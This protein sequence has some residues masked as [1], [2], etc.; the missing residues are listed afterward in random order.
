M[1]TAL[2][3]NLKIHPSTLDPQ[4]STLNTNPH[5]SIMSAKNLAFRGDSPETLGGAGRR[6]CK[7]EMTRTDGSAGQRAAYRTRRTSTRSRSVLA[8]LPTEKAD[9]QQDKLPEE[10]SAESDGWVPGGVAALPAAHVDHPVHRTH[11][12]PPL[13]PRLLL[14]RQSCVDRC[15]VCLSS[16]PQSQVGDQIA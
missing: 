2:T 9:S 8:I 10:E 6:R 1:L 3:S 16:N 14:G 11:G 12:V 5:F 13:A 15:I 7:A 4:P